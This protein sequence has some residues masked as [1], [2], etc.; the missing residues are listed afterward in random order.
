[1]NKPQQAGATAG[2]VQ[3]TAKFSRPRQ[4]KKIRD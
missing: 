3:A 1:M 4:G 2:R